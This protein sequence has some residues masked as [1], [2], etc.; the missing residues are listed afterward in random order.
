MPCRTDS[1]STSVRIDTIPV[2]C[3]TNKTTPHSRGH[4]YDAHYL[5]MDQQDARMIP[6][7]VGWDPWQG[8]RPRDL[9]GWRRAP[10]PMIGVEALSPTK[11]PGEQRPRTATYYMYDALGN[12]EMMAKT[13]TDAAL[14]RT[15]DEQSPCYSAA[16]TSTVAPRQTLPR[17]SHK[18]MTTVTPRRALED[19]VACKL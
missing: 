16:M 19:D 17:H 18:T 13:M 5:N 11:R 3:R 2:P 4:G 15:A 7:T 1:S 14:H 8:S 10:T 6:S 12:L 9:P